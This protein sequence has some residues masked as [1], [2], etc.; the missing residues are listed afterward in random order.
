MATCIRGGN[1]YKRHHYDLISGICRACNK[2]KFATE[3][4]EIDNASEKESE[5]SLD[6]VTEVL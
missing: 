5:I 6:N 4:V 2:Y 1:L 3:N